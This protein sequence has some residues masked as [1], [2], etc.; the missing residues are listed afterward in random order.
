MN[1]FDINSQDELGN[2]VLHFFVILYLNELDD[3]ND[4]EIEKLRKIIKMLIKYEVN[5]LLK[6]LEGKTARQILVGDLVFLRKTE[7]DDGW[8]RFPEDKKMLDEIEEHIK[9][10]EREVYIVEKSQAKA[11]TEKKLKEAKEKLERDSQT[12]EKHP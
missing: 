10:V 7:K 2:T 4:S 1:I 5:L 3:G 6:N 11:D 9:K 12:E 8:K